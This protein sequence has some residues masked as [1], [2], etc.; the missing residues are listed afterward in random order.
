MRKFIF[1][2]S[3]LQ[4]LVACNSSKKATILSAAKAPFVWEGSNVYFLL[5]DR[6]YNADSTNDVSFGRDKKAAKLRG[7][8][9]GD[10]KGVIKKIEDNYFSD[11]GIN[12][13]WLTPIVEQ[14]HGSVDEGTGNTYGFH[15]YWAKDWT[16]LDP[17]FGTK[18]E[19][20]RLVEKAHEKGI[21]I[22][23]DT[24][25]NHTGPVT[26]QD[27]VYPN[28][29]VR[30]SPPC[31]YNTYK[32]TTQCTLVENLPDV[33]TESR[34]NVDLPPML[35]EK[36]KKEGRY[37]KEIA[38]LNVFFKK[39]GYPR[40]PKYYIM[41]WLADY[42]KKYGIDGYRV[43]T[44]K[45]TDPDVWADFAEVCQTA[46]EEYKRQHPDQ[47]F[48]QE[49]FF[50]IGELY[51]YGISQKQEY[52]F[53][54]KKINY[55][56][57]GFPALINFD[58]KSDA[59]QD[60]ETIFA[61]YSHILHHELKGNSVMN[62]ISS[63]DDG[64]PFDRERK[65]PY[66]AG[67]KLL[68]APGIAQI[69]YGDEV[70]RSLVI[71]GAEGDANLR[72]N[73]NWEEIETNPQKQELLIHYQRLGKFRKNHPSVGAGVHEMISEKPYWFSRIYTKGNY[74][75]KVVVG[76]DLPQG[77]KTAPVSSVFVNGALLKDAY[78]GEKAVVKNGK[79]ELN[80]PYSIVL[81]EQSK[82]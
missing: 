64:S 12:A 10:L 31:Q 65:K 78:S 13:I 37:D 70:A 3:L 75:D 23:L 16:N 45:H 27:P 66:M 19:L 56:K 81:L 72:S 18:E 61:K 59:H 54:D 28:K 11:L 14:I 52:A 60:Y 74:T 82:P 29:W 50:L 77:K 7:F 9:G 6:F 57:N 38:E 51:G 21:K 43:D 73:M 71:D 69:Y 32:N 15:G 49:E 34:E 62:Y 80:T 20:K 41:K 47:D 4:L 2:F 30:T 53:P 17:N 42:I 1:I 55:F 8:E 39:T 40:A 26:D 24:V 58:F 22:L 36:W 48:D 79:V 33:R 67:T 25:I 76:L 44:V 68:L 35:V 5:T 63:H 46:F